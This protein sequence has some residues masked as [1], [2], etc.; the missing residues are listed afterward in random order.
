MLWFA[1]LMFVTLLCNVVCGCC[2]YICVGVVDV[3]GLT[4]RLM[5][6]NCVCVSY[7][8]VELLVVVL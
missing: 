8:L 1:L 5:C 4:A 7:A 2:C 3:C 6:L